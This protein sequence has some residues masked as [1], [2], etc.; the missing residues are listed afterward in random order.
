MNRR[1]DLEV[2]PIKYSEETLKLIDRFCLFDD[3][4][5]SKVF[6]GNIE[7]TELVLNII[8]ERDDM[9]VIDVVGQRLIKG[10]LP[11]GRS[12]RLDILAKDSTGKLY[13]IEVQQEKS[14]ALPRRAR[15]HSSVLDTRTLKEKQKFKE[16]LDSYVIF[17]TR[18]DYWEAGFPLYHV[19]RNI[20][21]IKKD[22]EDG[23][24]I[25]YVNGSYEGDDPI[26]RLV[27]DF[28]CQKS[29]ELYYDP[30]RKSFHHFKETDEGR[31]D[32]CQLVEEYADKKAEK[33][34]ENTW[35]EAIKSV[36]DKMKY[37]AEEA[38]DL[39]NVP[40]ESRAALKKQL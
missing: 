8:L 25:I 5:M 17:F 6:D 3:T 40:V 33:K 13:N 18:D 36:M 15:F 32:M 24:H 29:E 26:G 12:I 30:L 20:K 2:E 21:E 28:K 23:S 37:S 4:F 16:L 9:E 35:I 10:E 11:D 34:E 1:N 19:E 7:A 22:F 38:M 31:N 39:I 14:G 27:H